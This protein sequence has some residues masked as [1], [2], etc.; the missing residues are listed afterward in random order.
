[1]TSAL[2]QAFDKASSLPADQQEALAAIVLDEI[3][4]EQRWKAA[5]DCSQDALARL[6]AEALEEDRQRRTSDLSEL[7]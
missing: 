3:A 7:L 1:M 4:S 5:F 6:A 2:Q